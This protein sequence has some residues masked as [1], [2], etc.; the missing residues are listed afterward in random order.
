MPWK[1]KDNKYQIR[2]NLEISHNND[3]N[4]DTIT[5]ASIHLHEFDLN[6][7]IETTIW[8]I[9]LINHLEE[10]LLNL[11]DISHDYTTENSLFVLVQHK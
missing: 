5:T 6:C 4:I 8:S 11:R 7:L 3:G 10:I 2:I 1:W 9:L